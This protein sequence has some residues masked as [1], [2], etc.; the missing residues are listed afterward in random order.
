MNL[1]Q[2]TSKIK[3]EDDCWI[4]QAGLNNKGY[5]VMWHEKKHFIVHRWIYKLVYGNIPDGLTIDHL[6]RHR[7]CVNPKHL[8]AVTNSENLIR[9][10]G[11][12]LA[13]MRSMRKHLKINGIHMP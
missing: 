10:A 8:E 4:W 5:A 1:D 6:C 7:R 13:R 2:I 12:I 11:P 9:G 3:V